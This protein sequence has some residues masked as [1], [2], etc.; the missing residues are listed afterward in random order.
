[1]VAL[2]GWTPSVTDVQAQR[3]REVAASAGSRD[4]FV[5]ALHDDTE[6]GNAWVGAFLAPMTTSDTT[7]EGRI[8]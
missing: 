2:A 7:T 5:A 8:E 3:L 4:E 1:M 6:I